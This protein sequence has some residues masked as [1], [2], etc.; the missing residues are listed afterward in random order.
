MQVMLC[1]IE[2]LQFVVI[3]SDDTWVILQTTSMGS[4]L[5]SHYCSL[6][7]QLRAYY[8]EGG[9]WAAL[10]FLSESSVIVC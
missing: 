8:I 4:C 9:D 5:C 1:R 6:D 3:T 2:A 10:L 7:F